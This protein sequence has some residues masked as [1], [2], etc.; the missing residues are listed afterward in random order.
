MRTEISYLRKIEKKTFKLF[1]TNPKN[2]C[3]ILAFIL[4]HQTIE[5]TNAAKCQNIVKYPKGDITM[6]GQIMFYCRIIYII[7]CLTLKLSNKCYNLFDRLLI[8]GKVCTS[9]SSSCVLNTFS[10][11]INSPKKRPRASKVSG[12]RSI[13]CTSMLPSEFRFVNDTSLHWRSPLAI[14]EGLP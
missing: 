5:F 10:L 9:I 14:V 4:F 6:H 11:M 7:C 13:F 3:D 12:V 8:I 1:I 2:L